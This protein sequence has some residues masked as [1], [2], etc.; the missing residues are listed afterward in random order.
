MKKT[1]HVT[2]QAAVAWTKYE[3]L[4]RLESKMF[5]T[6]LT[7]DFCDLYRFCWAAIFLHLNFHTKYSSLLGTKPLQPILH[8]Y[9]LFFWVHDLIVIVM[10]AVLHLRPLQREAL[11]L[12]VSRRE[13][14]DRALAPS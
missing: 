10:L 11:A 14:R 1:V 4:G 7:R 9:K 5:E 8:S 3:E 6:C 13:S 2:L 12:A